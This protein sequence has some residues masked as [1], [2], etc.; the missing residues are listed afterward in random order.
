MSELSHAS[1]ATFQTVFL[2]GNVELDTLPSLFTLDSDAHEV[3]GVAGTGLALCM[4]SLSPCFVG[5][6]SAMPD[7]L[8]PWKWQPFWC[9]DPHCASKMLLL[10]RCF[11]VAS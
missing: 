8:L 10:S 7:Y 1:H 3:T 6:G 9:A 2:Q 5:K 11:A 4:H